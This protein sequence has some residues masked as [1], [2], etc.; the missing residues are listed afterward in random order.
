MLKSK[1][2][3]SNIYVWITQVAWVVGKILLFADTRIKDYQK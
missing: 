1:S 3:W 2:L